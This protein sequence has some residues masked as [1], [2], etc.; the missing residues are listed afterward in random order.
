MLQLNLLLFK[1]MQTPNCCCCCC[2]YCCSTNIHWCLYTYSDQYRSTLASNTFEAKFCL[3]AWCY[4]CCRWKC[5]FNNVQCTCTCHLFIGMKSGIQ[6]WM[7]YI[8]Q[9]IC[10]HAHNACSQKK[11]KEESI[12]MHTWYIHI[13]MEKTMATKCR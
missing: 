11:K 2:C 12:A 5:K 9:Q 13:C 1:T 3:L 4:C 10:M 7:K 6:A 8:T